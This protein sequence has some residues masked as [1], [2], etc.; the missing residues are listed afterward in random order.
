MIP[1]DRVPGRYHWNIDGRAN[2]CTM[3]E[4]RRHRCWV[5]HGDPATPGALHV[6]K[7]GTTCKAGAG[8]IAVPGFHA[9]LQH[10]VLRQC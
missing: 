8:S 5:R 1:H 6:D 2:N 4:D 9:M 7:T 3:P 10:G